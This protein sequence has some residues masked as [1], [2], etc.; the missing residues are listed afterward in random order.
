MMPSE[1]R[2]LALVICLDLFLL[3]VVTGSPSSSRI[4]LKNDRMSKKHTP[5]KDEKPHSIKMKMKLWKCLVQLRSKIR[6]HYGVRDP[7]Q[8]IFKTKKNK[9]RN[10]YF[11][12]AS[13]PFPEIL[14]TVIPMLS[15]DMKKCEHIWGQGTQDV[16]TAH[17]QVYFTELLSAKINVKGVKG[18]SE[19]Q[20]SFGLN[21]SQ[22]LFNLI[23]FLQE[24]LVPLFPEHCYVQALLMKTRPGIARS[25]WKDMCVLH[26][27][28]TEENLQGC[29]E[30]DLP[31]VI[32]MPLEENY[33]L[34]IG[35]YLGP[36]GKTRKPAKRKFASAHLGGF[37]VCDARQYHTSAVAKWD[38]P[39]QKIRRSSSGSEKDDVT[40]EC[41]RLH[42]TLAKYAHHITH[43][44]QTVVVNHYRNNEMP[45]HVSETM[46]EMFAEEDDG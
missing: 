41:T 34:E 42:F 5:D 13:K 8:P 37:V 33:C 2:A 23:L 45:I 10:G 18:S 36:H 20:T 11:C 15:T 6:D 32:V 3:I 46:K 4:R 24:L 26:S 17:K 21:A 22:E 38:S 19:F 40:T 1:I 25:K 16:L 31:I 35:N 30:N 7:L 39:S 9:R 14:R 12:L 29:S 43:R 27:D 28:F 44:Q